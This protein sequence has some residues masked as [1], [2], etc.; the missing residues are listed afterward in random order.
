VAYNVIRG[1]LST[2]VADTAA[3][4][5]ASVRELANKTQ[6]DIAT[7]RVHIPA[8]HVRRIGTPSA[9]VDLECVKRVADGDQHVLFAVYRV[10]L[11]RVGGPESPATIHVRMPVVS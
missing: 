2:R 4:V 3:C 11:R 8:I 7:N 10:R 5:A 1:T 6:H 9:S